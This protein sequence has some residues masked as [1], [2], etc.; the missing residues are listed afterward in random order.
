MEHTA[1][2]AKRPLEAVD[3]APPSKRR[4]TAA[5]DISSIMHAIASSRSAKRVQAQIVLTGRPVSTVLHHTGLY[6]VTACDLSRKRAPITDAVY[7]LLWCLMH[8]ACPIE[9]YR[10]TADAF[11]ALPMAW[12]NALKRDV[13]L[14]RKRHTVSNLIRRLDGTAFDCAPR[15]ERERQF[16]AAFR[17][18]FPEHAK[19][20]SGVVPEVRLE[21][22]QARFG[23]LVCYR[24]FHG[25]HSADYVTVVGHVDAIP[26]S[27]FVEYDAACDPDRLAGQWMRE[28]AERPLSIGAGSGRQP[29]LETEY[30]RAKGA[31][32]ALPE[33][34]AHYRAAAE[35]HAPERFATELRELETRGYCVFDLPGDAEHGAAWLEAAQ[36][37]RDEFMAFFNWALFERSGRPELGPLSLDDRTADLW[38][39]LR[40]HNEAARLTGE[41]HF[42]NLSKLDAASGRVVH[43][44]TSQGGQSLCTISH[45]MGHATNFYRGAAWLALGAHPLV[46]RAMTAV[47]GGERCYM[48]PERLRVKCASGYIS[49]TDA[50]HTNIMQPHEDRVF[51]YARQWGAAQL[52]AAAASPM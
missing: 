6:V 16:F 11:A 3:P 18:A 50:V 36:A 9:T 14:D 1:T 47:Y 46:A 21:S 2:T 32:P 5:P 52:A 38:N 28:F 7:P 48:V 22:V 33:C 25:N 51:P 41:P 26:R 27:Q 39:I 35:Q 31:V 23:Q 40:G 45:G 29:L 20:L 34:D 19:R 49:G 43:S 12:P 24:G 30:Y 44:R 4:R 13:M 17:A 15:D 37:A 8:P 10:L 42:L